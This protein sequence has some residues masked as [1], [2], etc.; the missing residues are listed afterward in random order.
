MDKEVEYETRKAKEEEFYATTQMKETCKP[1]S[2]A[3]SQMSSLIGCLK[4]ETAATREAKLLTTEN[5]GNIMRQPNQ[6]IFVTLQ[7]KHLHKFESSSFL[8]KPK[9]INK[10]FK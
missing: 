3:W 2:S 9:I 1:G 7:M 6:P 8:F 10:K 5:Q 4:K